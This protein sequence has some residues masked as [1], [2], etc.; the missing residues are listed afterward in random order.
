MIPKPVRVLGKE[1]IKNNKKRIYKD[2]HV[3][4]PTI[5]Y[6]YEEIYY[7]YVVDNGVFCIA[8]NSI[9]HIEKGHISLI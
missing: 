1:W 5:V 3:Q 2:D 9:E 6:C 4:C 8:T 7:C